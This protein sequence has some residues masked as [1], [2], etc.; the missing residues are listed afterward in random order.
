MGG[1]ARPGDWQASFNAG[2]WSAELDAR[3][4]IETYYAAA[5]KLRGVEPRP[6]GGFKKLPGSRQVG[7]A[8]NQATAIANSRT[9]FNASFTG[10]ANVA[11]LTFTGDPAP[12]SHV[13]VANARCS[14]GAGTLQVQYQNMNDEWIDLGPTWQVTP[15]ASS[16]T[17]ALPPNQPVL[18][19][20]VRITCVFGGAGA[21]FLAGAAVTAFA[22]AGTLPAALRLF[23]F[24]FSD[25]D[26]QILVVQ[27]GIV[28]FWRAG[29]WLGAV[30]GLTV[31]SAMLPD[32]DLFFDA[33]TIGLFHPDLRSLRLVRVGGVDNQW[34]LDN[35]P[36][37]DIG[38]AIYP[39]GNYVLRPERYRID[40]S[41]G[42]S[43]PAQLSAVATIDGSETDG[44]NLGVKPENATGSDWQG[45][46]AAMQADMRA[47]PY[48]S[49]GLTVTDIDSGNTPTARRFNVEFGGDL[50]G[51]NYAFAVRVT[52]TA[53]YAATVTRT[54]KGNISGEP[55]ISASR[56]W[57]AT[58][59]LVQERMFYAGIKAK[60]TAM[61]ASQVGE[62]FNLNTDAGLADSAFAVA[63]RE[64]ISERI[65]H[66][67]WEKYLLMFT[68][69]GE[70]FSN[71]R[72]F[73][74]DQ[75]VN[76]VNASNNG[77]RR[78]VWPRSA[79]GLVWYCDP[80]GNV[81]YATTYDDV[82][83]SFTSVNRSELFS[84]L[85]AGVIQS[86]MRRP[87]AD[88][89]GFRLLFVRDDGRLVQVTTLRKHD[90]VSACEWETDGQILSVAVDR[91]NRV[92][93]AVRRAYAGGD[94]IDIELWDDAQ[95][96]HGAVD[97]G[98]SD[99]NG[100]VSGLSPREGQQVWVVADGHSL[101][102]FTV[103]DGAITLPRA[104]NQVS[105]GWW[106][107]P[108]AQTLPLYNTLAEGKVL[109]RPGRLHTARVRVAATT[110]IAIGT[111]AEP[112]VDMPLFAAGHAAN[113][114]VPPFGGMVE[115]SG[116]A[117]WQIGPSL[118]VTQVRPGALEVRDCVLEGSL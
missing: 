111:S 64:T 9:D 43:G 61:L 11:I 72:A 13:L 105:V 63:V 10:T 51:Y 49:N 34:T 18:A 89:D 90:L 116:M 81:L 109:R 57:P 50:A 95:W 20:A 59:R 55:W 104:F 38:K 80:D 22:N 92:Q 53:S 91:Q 73:A 78:S 35:W 1:L 77:S 33:N 27:E 47:L 41:Y 62:Y 86:A 46:A 96:L 115:R 44:N 65:Q 107:P 31:T 87:D 2:E 23:D 3:V 114:P 68:D 4:D 71:N 56:G 66:V 99:A 98:A 113:A 42:P 32:L 54:L 16:R 85:F 5:L 36:Y 97:Y 8:R 58:A 67:I 26:T 82:Q 39:D 52:N 108:L 88:L 74:A 100:V 29:Q 75:P 93:L 118:I 94:S 60:P 30:A 69:Q 70:Y 45:L 112:P 14:T 7:K 12:L 15:T 102:R 83:T 6:K 21:A 106:T 40:F 25:T 84:H 79:E 37:D 103:A 17:R 19:K 28:D 48:M 110:S 101:G 76:F 117:D 24:T